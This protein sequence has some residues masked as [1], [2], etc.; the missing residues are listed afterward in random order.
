MSMQIDLAGR[1]A[2]VTGA[3]S[4]LGEQFAKTLASAGAAVVLAARR[5]ERLK[6][7]RAEIESHGGV[8]H[9]VALDVTDADSIK[10]AVA[11]AETEMG[12]IDILVNNSGVSTTQRLVDVEPE[13]YDY[14]FDTNTRGAFFVAQEV[15]KRMIARAKG[16]AP[17]AFVGGRIVNVASMAGLRPLQ[18]IGVYAMSKAAVVHMTRAMALEWGRY[19]INVNALCPGYIDTEIN[20][21]HWETEAGQKLIAMLPRKRVGKP[22]DLDSSLLMLC[23]NESHFINGAVLQA[24][25]GFGI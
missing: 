16:A 17:G 22:A 12:T 1:V 7:L 9:V 3:S 15:G 13:D 5:V 4:G 20:H 21:R 18:Q 11:H 2:L 6:T 19:G 24:D 14:M 23:A 8:A 10:S 25:D